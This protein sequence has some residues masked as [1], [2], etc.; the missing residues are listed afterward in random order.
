MDPMS[1]DCK[2]PYLDIIKQLCDESMKYLGRNE[3]EKAIELLQFAQS[4][5]NNPQL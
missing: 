3:F 2:I 5:S 4:I 1:E